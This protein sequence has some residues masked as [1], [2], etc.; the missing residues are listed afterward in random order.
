MSDRARGVV[1]IVFAIGLC[2][3]LETI[4]LGLVLGWLAGRLGNIY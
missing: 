3:M 2:V 1:V 4:V